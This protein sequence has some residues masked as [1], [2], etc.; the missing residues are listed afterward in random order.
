MR[1]RE[2]SHPPVKGFAN[3]RR[4]WDFSSLI[5]QAA[6]KIDRQFISFRTLNLANNRFGKLTL[7]W[8]VTSSC[9]TLM[10][11]WKNWHIN[12]FGTLI[13]KKYETE[14]YN[15]NILGREKGGWW[16]VHGFL[17]QNRGDYIQGRW[18]MIGLPSRTKAIINMCTDISAGHMDEQNVRV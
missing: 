16:Q 3:L 6:V 4:C 8:L 11:S 15:V 17:W 9:L 18:A 14:K 5:R 13:W 1:H 2:Y 7:V 10:R 12:S